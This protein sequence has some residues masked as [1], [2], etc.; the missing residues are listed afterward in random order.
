MSAWALIDAPPRR[1][2]IP[3]KRAGTRLV[4]SRIENSESDQMAAIARGDRAAFQRLFLIY[5]PRVKAYLMRLGAPGA[6]AEEMAQDALFS[7]W[8]RAAS[9][10]PKRAGVSTWIFVI[11]RNCW[12]D[13]LRREKLELAYRSANIDDEARESEAE[14]IVL[15]AE[16]EGRVQAAMRHLSEDQRA[17]VRLSFFEEKT[18][19]EIA[20]A[21]SQPLGTVKSR[22]RLAM[23]KLRNHLEGLA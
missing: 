1:K 13:R 16:R 17:V 9:F 14:D 3:D 10:D 23:A 19:S 8:R 22:L 12:I 7:V 2:Q 5:A 15:Q 4:H 6:A 21:L 11:A 20:V 18:H